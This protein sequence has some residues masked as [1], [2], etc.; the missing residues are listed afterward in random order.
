MSFRAWRAA[1]ALILAAGTVFPPFVPASARSLAAIRESGSVELCAHPNALPFSSKTAEP[2]G[3][4][5]ELGQALAKEIG[6]SL[7]VDWV[8]IAYQIPR[9][10]CD[11]VLDMV[12]DPSVELDYGIRLT[13]PY[14]RSGVG[15]AVPA[16]SRLGSF[17]ELDRHTKVGVLVGSVAAMV[18]D[19]R[20]VTI[21]V[22]GFED[23]IL[24]ALANHEID[25][26]AVTPIA[27][28]YYGFR[29]TET[30][31]RMIWPDETDPD[32]VWNVG[33]GIRKPDDALRAEIEQAM[34]RLISNGTIGRIYAGYGI[35][36]RP[37][38]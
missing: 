19:K 13:K 29:H 2:P 8:L 33:I 7:T 36:L 28:Q 30:L 20:H 5:I 21:S 17:A 9:T 31:L 4:Q 10:S 3:F 38:R 26:G 18:L 32:L 16:S 1:S 25:A 37:P 15:L 34:E 12:A 23:D 22:F 14:Y 27:A 35:S 24:A 6:V 11:L